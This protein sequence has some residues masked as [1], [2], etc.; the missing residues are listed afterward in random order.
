MHVFLGFN[1]LHGLDVN[2]FLVSH[3]KDWLVKGWLIDSQTHG[4][5]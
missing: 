5:I 2:F 1:V 4:T 3:C